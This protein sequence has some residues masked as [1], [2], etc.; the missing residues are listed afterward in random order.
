VATLHAISPSV[1]QQPIPLSF[2][3]KPIRFSPRQV[4]LMAQIANQLSPDFCRAVTPYWHQA[5]L[6]RYLEQ[7]ADDESPNISPVLLR[8]LN[9]EQDGAMFTWT[10]R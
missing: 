6:G 2:E 1:P 5:F 7:L 4:A 9:V 8:A 10:P 3:L